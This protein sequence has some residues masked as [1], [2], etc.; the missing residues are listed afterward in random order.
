[1]TGS[2]K[3]LI[4]GNNRKTLGNTSFALEEDHESGCLNLH[5]KFNTY[6]GEQKKKEGDKNHAR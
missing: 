6:Q 4:L 1:M 5:T 2:R 3:N